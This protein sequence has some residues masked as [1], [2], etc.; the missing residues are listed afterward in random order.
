MQTKDL[1][2]RYW[3]RVRSIKVLK[4]LVD[5]ALPMF[6]E[7][8]S[9]G[10]DNY[11]MQP[12]PWSVY[13]HTDIR[14]FLLQS[15]MELGRIQ[16]H[17]IGHS[18]GEGADFGRAGFATS[19]LDELGLNEDDSR[20][21]RIKERSI[22][23]VVIGPIPDGVRCLLLRTPGLKIDGECGE[24]SCKDLHFSVGVLRCQ[25]GESE[26]RLEHRLELSPDLVDLQLRHTRLLALIEKRYRVR[27]RRSPGAEQQ[28][29]PHRDLGDS[30][31]RRDRACE[32]AGLDACTVERWRKRPDGEDLRRS[33]QD[34]AGKRTDLGR[35]S[36]STLSRRR[37]GELATAPEFAGLS[38]HQ[39]VPKLAGTSMY[40]ASESTN[41]RRCAAR[42]RQMALV[43]GDDG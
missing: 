26:V 18:F 42:P 1:R 21:R 40:L 19:F 33:P 8:A 31:A 16:F 10:R 23:S 36:E 35:G 28:T 17:D 24:G 13:R 22:D 12:Y 39:L 30:F 27:A 43:E 2:T 20:L 6:G 14:K 38:P 9:A 3:I 11:Q 32:V 5:S 7:R 41:E 4:E 15:L 37:I 29:E 34:E 25:V